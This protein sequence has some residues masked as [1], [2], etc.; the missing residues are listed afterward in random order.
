MKHFKF[1]SKED[2]LSLTKIRRFETKL[3]ERVKHIAATGNWQEAL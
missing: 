1:Y 3:G 2:I